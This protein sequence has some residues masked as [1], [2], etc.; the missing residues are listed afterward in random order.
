V[1]D[2]RFISA[3]KRLGEVARKVDSLRQKGRMLS[4]NAEAFLFGFHEHLG[5]IGVKSKMDTDQH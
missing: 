5:Q 1:R 3:R 4:V 2:E